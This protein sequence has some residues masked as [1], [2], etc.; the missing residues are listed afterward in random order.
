MGHTI[1]PLIPGLVP[2]KTCERWAKDLQGLSLRN[3]RITF[4]YD[5][6]RIVSEIGECVFTH[7]GISGPLVLDLSGRIAELIAK[8][9]KVK[10]SIDL[11][12]GLAREKLDKR[13]LRD[14]AEGSNTYLRNIMR[15]LLPNRMTGISLKLAGIDPYKKAN[16]ITRDERRFVIDILK[17]F[18]LT[19]A[20]TL[21]IEHAMITSGGVS[22]GEI[23]PRTMQSRIVKGIY[24]AGEII[25]GSAPS[26][27]YNLQQAFST[28]YLAG[29]SAAHA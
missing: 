25:E 20:G 7:F 26:G 12:P 11:K 29:E 8:G 14:L 6:K 28:G 3:V 13:L 9:D 4:Y 2:L 27:G 22:V 5:K 10:A 16:Q 19:I 17:G 15:S 23:D 24:F 18:P 1:T 21:P